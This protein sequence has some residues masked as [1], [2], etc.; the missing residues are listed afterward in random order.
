MRS[1]DTGSGRTPPLHPTSVI[2]NAK[3][4]TPPSRVFDTGK[5][6]ATANST[7][8]VIAS[9]AGSSMAES[10]KRASL[11]ESESGVAAGCGGRS[12]GGGCPRAN[13]RRDDIWSAISCKPTR[14]G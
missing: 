2:P 1:F 3:K 6:I 10:T 13:I 14:N 11:V 9:V 8:Y 4:G 7:L 12:G 5:A